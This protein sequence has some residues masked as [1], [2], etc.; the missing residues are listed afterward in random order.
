MYTPPGKDKTSKVDKPKEYT[1][2]E[3]QSRLISMGR[4][5]LVSISFRVYAI[6]ATKFTFTYCDMPILLNQNSKYLIKSLSEQ[7]IVEEGDAYAKLSIYYEDLTYWLS[8]NASTQFIK[9]VISLD[10]SG[11]C[12]YLKVTK[13]GLSNV[14]P[15]FKVPT[16]S[17]TPTYFSLMLLAK[18]FNDTLESYNTQ[19]YRT[20]V[21]PI[22]LA[23]TET[24][25]VQPTHTLF[26]VL[27]IT[28]DN[29]A[30]FN[31]AMDTYTSNNGYVEFS[32]NGLM[33]ADT[34]HG[35]VI[36]AVEMDGGTII[37]EHIVKQLY[38]LD[39]TKMDTLFLDDTLSAG[40]VEDVEIGYTSLPSRQAITRHCLQN[41]HWL[42]PI[43][44]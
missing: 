16:I 34:F 28:S 9:Q 15:L 29:L 2:E 22:Y 24:N 6:A 11:T 17:Q 4:N 42:A 12:K 44:V 43:P 19:S 20:D 30:T 35:L 10:T 8:K 32:T 25:I 18:P 33:Y 27:K 36:Y 26:L 37:N 5:D 23:E 7:T 1:R 40:Q 13:T 31:S 39:K 38:V 21:F 41:T 3:K 14:E